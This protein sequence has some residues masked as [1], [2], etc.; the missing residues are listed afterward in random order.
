LTP[1]VRQPACAKALLS[2]SRSLAISWS[3]RGWLSIRSPDCRVAWA[4]Q[5]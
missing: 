3:C 5:L 4:S 1:T 2:V